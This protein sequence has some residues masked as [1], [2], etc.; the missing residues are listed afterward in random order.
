[1]MIDDLVGEM[2]GA[3]VA[4]GCRIRALAEQAGTGE[5][6]ARCDRLLGNAG[7]LAFKDP[8]SNALALLGGLVAL[9]DCVQVAL[10]TA[11]QAHV[12]AAKKA[13]SGTSVAG[14]L[15]PT[16]CERSVPSPSSGTP[17]AVAV[18]GGAPG[19]SRKRA[20]KAA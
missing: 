3:S 10:E 8:A 13:A 17:A 15:G 11:D 12:L 6:A 5:S 19:P 16:K 9:S 14:T 7:R 1:M 20:G 2:A 4:L 18:A